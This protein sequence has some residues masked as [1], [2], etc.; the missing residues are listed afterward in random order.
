M[1]KIL[2]TTAERKLI[3]IFI[4]QK[5]AIKYKIE[6]QFTIRIKRTDYI[7]DFAIPEI[8]LSIE[9]DGELFHSSPSQIKRDEKTVSVLRKSGWEVLR[10]W[11][12]EVKSRNNS[13]VLKMILDTILRLEIEKKTKVNFKCEKDKTQSQALEIATQTVQTGNPIMDFLE[14]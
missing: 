5:I 8:K 10:F 1:S 9:I 2:Y 12:Y 4:K 6:P 7:V 14:V 13:R 11:D 3:R